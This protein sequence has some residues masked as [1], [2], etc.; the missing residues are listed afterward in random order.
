MDTD[1]KAP[2]ENRNELIITKINLNLLLKNTIIKSPKYDI[3]ML[4][5]IETY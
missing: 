2:E 4:I 1:E 3:N 5:E